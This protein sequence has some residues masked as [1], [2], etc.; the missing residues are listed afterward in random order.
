MTTQ[1]RGFTA[2]FLAAAAAVM[3]GCAASPAE[4]PASAATPPVRVVDDSVAGRRARIAKLLEEQREANRILGWA[5]AIVQDDRVIYL[6]A[7]GLRDLER[8]LPVTVDTLFPIGSCTK[9]FTALAAAI[10]QER[11]LLSLDDH[12][13]RHLPAFKMADP[14]ADAKVTI[15]DMLSHR[16]GLRHNADLAAEPGVLTRAE[17]VRAATSARPAVSFRS[18]FEYSNAM[19]TAVGEVL[20]RARGATWEEVIEADLLRP[21]GMTSTV[22]TLGALAGSPRRTTGYVI[23]DDGAGW[24]PVAPPESLAAMGPAGSISSTARDMTAWLR[25]L[26]GKGALDGKRIVSEASLGEVLRPHMR[27]NELTSYGLGWG[28]Y[29]WKGN[30]WS[31]TAA[32]LPA[33]ARW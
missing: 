24:R 4:P 12:P 2:A 20:G 29:Q 10:G 9:S 31:R 28:L 22:T 19:F 27:M 11:G 26:L 23:A 14:E 1:P 18:A 25:L 32:A 30:G 15:R 6:D 21:L 13:R 7:S 17:Y 5:V 33:S 8:K 16:T 3:C